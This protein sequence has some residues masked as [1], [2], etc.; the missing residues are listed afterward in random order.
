MLVI[1]SKET[2][3]LTAGAQRQTGAE[4]SAA[5]AAAVAAA[6]IVSYPYPLQ[7]S[8]KQSPHAMSPVGAERRGAGGLPT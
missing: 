7:A 6:A 8:P 4:P 3:Y 1:R 2:S 5:D